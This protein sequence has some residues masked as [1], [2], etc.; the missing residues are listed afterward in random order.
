M[1]DSILTTSTDITD[2]T[3]STPLDLARLRGHTNICDYL[4]SIPSKQ[5]GMFTDF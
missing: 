3:G 4:I 5:P 1:I 2:D